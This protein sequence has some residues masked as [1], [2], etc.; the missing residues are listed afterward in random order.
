MYLRHQA[1]GGFDA[2]VNLGIK[3]ASQGL[4][5]MTK[6]VFYHQCMDKTWA[7]LKGAYQDGYQDSPCLNTL[8]SSKGVMKGDMPPLVPSYCHN[9]VQRD[10]PTR[11]AAFLII[12]H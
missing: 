6:S 7:G 12:V 2:D 9:C 8:Q 4:L 10:K 3:N 11:F 5:C 1:H